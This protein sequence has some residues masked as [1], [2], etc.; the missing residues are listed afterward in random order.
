VKTLK[1]Q[2]ADDLDVFLN[3]DEFADE[4]TIGGE[5]VNGIF[6][7]EHT[8][9]LDVSGTHPAFTCKTSDVSGV[10]QGDTVTI[11]GTGYRVVS[12]KPDGTGMTTLVLEET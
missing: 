11:N 3:T 10:S 4:A 8:E 2:V 7:N 6:D 9:V 12:I 5:T 1:E